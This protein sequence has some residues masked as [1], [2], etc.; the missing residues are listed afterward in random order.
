M[1]ADNG[2]EV[3]QLA[4]KYHPELIFMDIKIPL[5]DGIK[6]TQ[7]L[8]KDP[9]TADIHIIALTASA[10]KS[11]QSLIAESGFDG[12]IPKPV[13]K[14]SIIKAIE[15]VIS[16]EYATETPEQK[17]TPPKTVESLTLSTKDQT[18]LKQ[19]LSQLHNNWLEIKDT[20][21]I[22]QIEKFAHDVHATAER[23]N[24]D[25][26]DDYAALL[27]EKTRYDIGQL[28]PVLKKFTSIAKSCIT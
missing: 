10:M 26:L 13:K 20:C 24:N 23:F 17:K 25:T 28:N 14:T 9:K 4:Q 21:I 15:K 7:R 11:E 12:F 3:I 1:E 5:L 2:L 8:R 22:S 27:L 19:Q 16:L 6:A 18:Q